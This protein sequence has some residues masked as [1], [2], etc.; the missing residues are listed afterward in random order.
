M[1][2][3]HGPTRAIAMWEMRGAARSRWLIGAA[4]IY[5]AAAVAL[6]LV[7]LRSLRDLGLGGTGAA[8]DGILALGVLLPPLV[9]LLLGATSLAGAREHGTLAILASQPIPRRAI[10][11]GIAAGLTLTLWAAIGAGLGLVAIVVSP[12][13]GGADLAALAVAT[14]ASLAAA[15]VGVSLGVA[16]SA[17][18]STRSQATAVAAAVWFA[19]ALG[20]DLLVAAVGPAI[21]IGPMAFL[22]TVLINPLESI[23]LL[24]FTLTDAA[25]LGPFGVYMADRFGTAGTAGILGTA[26]VAWIVFPAWLAV[27]TMRRRDVS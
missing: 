5:G 4:A 18:A 23:R 19:T 24:A 25:A 13:A 9:G 6:T 14:G 12:V 15:A 26:V 20:L 22:V 16:I 10:P 27:R 11:I 3:G 7:G 2:V 8:V 17:L 21:R 1:T